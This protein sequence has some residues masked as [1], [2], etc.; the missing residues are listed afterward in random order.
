ME[1]PEDNRFTPERWAL[2]KALFYNKAL[3]VDSSISCA[4][5][6]KLD[7]A[8]ADSLPTSPG[9]RQRAG[10]RNAPSLANVGYHPY[11]TREGGVPSLEMQALVPIQ[12]H[13]EFDFNIL[14]ITERLKE[15]VDLV[16]MSQA[17]Y[18]RDLDY[19]V[20]VRALATFQR[21][22]ISGNS[23]YDRYHFQGQSDAMSSSQLRGMELFNS[24][25]TN[26][27]K[28]HGGFNFTNYAFENNGLYNVYNDEGRKRLTNLNSDLARFKVPSLRNVE[29]TSPYMHDGAVSNLAEVIEHYDSG[30]FDHTN[31][32]HLIKP[33][34]LTKLEKADLLEFLNALTDHEFI[35][36]SKFRE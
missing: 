31:K 16:E 7:L 12:E 34:N 25:R 6:H 36:N 4:S 17:A 2:G 15:D 8:F 35:T 5:C 19:F 33:L 1:F 22:L 14:S 10:V 21:S 32:S 27:S 18:D 11:L 30:G 23:A 28:C 13:N 20:L 3:S 24:D 26:C 9:V 29:V